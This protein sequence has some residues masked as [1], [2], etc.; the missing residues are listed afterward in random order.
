MIQLVHN[1]KLVA[2]VAGS[3]LG[4]A[5]HFGVFGW[6]FGVASF[7]LWLWHIQLTEN[8]NPAPGFLFFLPYHLIGL[9]WLWCVT[10]PLSQH[11]FS[12][13]GPALCSSLIF[14]LAFFFLGKAITRFAFPVIP[15][16]IVGWM[17]IEYLQSHWELEFPWLRLVYLL[18][19]NNWMYAH[20][21]HVGPVGVGASIVLFSWGIL[22]AFTKRTFARWF[23]LAPILPLLIF[24]I[25]NQEL[26]SDFIQL[27]LVQPN[28]D[29]YSEKYIANQTD[30]SEKLWNLAGGGLDTIQC[31]VF[32]ETAFQERNMWEG[33]WRKSI[34]ISTAE[35]T[36]LA[37][38]H[39]DMHLGAASYRLLKPGEKLSAASRKF[40]DMDRYYES[41]NTAILINNKGEQIY[42]KSKLVA[43]V[44]C[45][46][47][48]NSLP[49][50]T[51]LSMDFGGTIGALGK[52]DTMRVLQGEN[53]N[54][55]AVI[56]YESVFP[57]FLRSWTKLGADVLVLMTNDAWWGNSVGHLQHLW[58]AQVVATSLGRPIA[59][60]AN[61]GIS[62]IIDAQ[63]E[64]LQKTE[65]NATGVL[66]GKL[67]LQKRWGLYQVFGDF[68]GFISFCVCA[69]ALFASL[70]PKRMLPQ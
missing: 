9:Q 14:Y 30:R 67:P 61:T 10:G 32:P 51:Q 52:Q 59:R 35:D 43:G 70:L 4:L 22:D 60:S 11:L 54:Y 55:G 49:F 7:A 12:W 50:M 28:E 34:A 64:V 13:L 58:R 65:F 15:S 62:A 41:Y 3:L 24:L 25:P 57:D 27:R 5:F 19:E 20:A 21:L 2:I 53:A 46:P 33:N 69:L 56:C 29:P 47:F 36:A 38:P 40:R 42:H 31:L 23:C 39:L 66:N 48:M 44:E 6:V 1:Q 17:G 16:F 18:G 26:T 63:G 68:L 37:Y 8:P 45:I